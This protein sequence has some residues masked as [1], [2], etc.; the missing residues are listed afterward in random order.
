MKT[1]SDENNYIKISPI[2]L[3]LK[4]HALQTSGISKDYSSLN[5]SREEII[6]LNPIN[7]QQTIKNVSKYIHIIN[8]QNVQNKNNFS[9][10]PEKESPKEGDRGK[11]T[12]SKF[13]GKFN[14]NP[15]IKKTYYQT[16]RYKPK[17]ATNFPSLKL[18]IKNNKAFFRNGN[19]DIEQPLNR[20][21]LENNI[22]S[23]D[24]IL[25]LYKERIDEEMIN[26]NFYI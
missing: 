17:R 2:H 5:N 22:K 14:F 4:S 9:T 26:R 8:Y 10:I 7:I 15:I 6:N 21:K 16:I 1:N 13:K 20:L 11:F 3:P 19:I 25:D 12:N 24:N 23:S 18:N